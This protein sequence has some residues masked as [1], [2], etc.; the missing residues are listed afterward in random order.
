M[1]LLSKIQNEVSASSMRAFAQKGE[2]VYVS[3]NDSNKID[4]SQN[5]AYRIC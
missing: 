5:F 3:K 4:F 2:L 1:P